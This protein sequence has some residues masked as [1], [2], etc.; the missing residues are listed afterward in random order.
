VRAF[1]VAVAVCAALLAGGGIAGAVGI[2]N[3]RRD[4]R[5]ATCSGGQLVGAP[6]RASE[7]SSSSVSA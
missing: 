4:V 2:V 3:P 1:H 5:A 7:A 6:V